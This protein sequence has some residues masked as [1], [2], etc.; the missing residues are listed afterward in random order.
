MTEK[1]KVADILAQYDEPVTYPLW[2][3]LLGDYQKADLT[4]D[5]LIIPVKLHNH[6][7][8]IK[9]KTGE[10]EEYIRWTGTD[11]DVM[12]ADGKEAE[13]YEAKLAETFEEHSHN[14]EVVRYER[15]PFV[16]EEWNEPA[17]SGTGLTAINGVD[18]EIAKR[19]N[20]AGY[21]TLDDLRATSLT[22]LANVD[23]ISAEKASSIY[24]YATF[25]NQYGPD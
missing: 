8:V 2:M 15:S 22:R 23:G 6:K 18:E 9:N 13:T 17:D 1:R 16:G 5:D 4:A 24:A 21:H 20:D 14:F 19:L 12:T 11:F 25:K 3:Y 7:L 10:Y